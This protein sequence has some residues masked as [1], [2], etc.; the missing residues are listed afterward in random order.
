MALGGLQSRM[1]P[2]TPVLIVRN[3]V[4]L[5]RNLPTLRSLLIVLLVFVM[6]VNAAPGT[7]PAMTPVPDP[8]KSTR[9][10]LLFRTR[11]RKK[12]SSRT[13]NVN[14]SRANSRS[15]RTP[16]AGM[17]TPQFLGNRLVL[18]PLRSRPRSLSFRLVM[19]RAWIR[20]LLCTLSL[21]IRL[22]LTTAVELM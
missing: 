20:D 9:C 3:P 11:P 1:F 5:V 19:H 18:V 17:T 21:R 4:G 2:G 7:L 22:W 10:E 15:N 14:G 16:L 6:L 8:L 12:N 13:T